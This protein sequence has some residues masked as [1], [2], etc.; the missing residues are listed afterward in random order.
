VLLV[1]LVAC[2]AVSTTAP[3]P[4]PAD[5]QG[6]ASEIVK[7][8]IAI[9]RLVSGDAG[10]DDPVLN[11]TAIAFDAKG[12]DQD[13]T[14]RLYLYIFRNRDSY[15]R[16]RST[17]DGCARAYVTDP[18]TFESIESSPFVLAGQGPWAP[19][20]DATLREALTVASGTGD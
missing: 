12:L 13:E 1:T 6:I 11:P 4:T 7:R 18:E 3:A 19:E 14:V 2:G 17:I 15:D 9:E 20:F 5:F 8:G 10:C 16:L